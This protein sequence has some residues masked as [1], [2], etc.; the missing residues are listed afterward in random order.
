[1][2]PVTQAARTADRYNMKLPGR[3]LRACPALAIR[4]RSRTR[5]C[6]RFADQVM[7]RFADQVM[8]L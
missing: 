2:H 1:L 4:D 3:P 7:I 6:G 8:M 5:C